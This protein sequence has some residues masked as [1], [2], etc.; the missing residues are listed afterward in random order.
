MDAKRSPGCVQ[1]ARNFN[2][3]ACNPTQSGA[4]FAGTRRGSRAEDGCFGLLLYLPGASDTARGLYLS[5]RDCGWRGP[6]GGLGAGQAI[7]Q[8]EGK[9]S[10]RFSEPRE[11]EVSRG[12]GVTH[13]LFLFDR[14]HRGD[15]G[16]RGDRRS[17]RR[18]KKS[19]DG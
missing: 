5:G 9:D 1:K 11:S 6:S 10:L 8:A 2:R 16:N 19:E 14:L 3:L 4:R 17:S 18:R 13:P 7:E 15:D 12:G